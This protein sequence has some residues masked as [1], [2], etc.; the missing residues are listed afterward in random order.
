[1][2]A[3]D[4]QRFDI[5]DRRQTV[6]VGLGHATQDGNASLPQR[7]GRQ[8]RD[9]AA[10]LERHGS[11]NLKD[12]R[13]GFGDD[14]KRLHLDSLLLPKQQLAPTAI[15]PT[16]ITSRPASLPDKR[17]F[18]TSI[19]SRQASLPDPHHFPTASLPDRITS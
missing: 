14:I 3:A 9:V 7:V 1:M 15:F 5:G 16:S 13:V 2:I 6:K 4:G 8:G 10:G 12:P 11:P 17:H 18:P 19:T